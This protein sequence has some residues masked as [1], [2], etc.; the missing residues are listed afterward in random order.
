M[1]LSTTSLKKQISSNA[2]HFTQR[3][4]LIL[5]IGSLVGCSSDVYI[6]PSMAWET[7]H[8]LVSR[9]RDAIHYKD[10]TSPLIWTSFFPK[11]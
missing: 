2:T 7:R 9:V 10:V 1:M 5:V 3:L 8:I 11:K 6:G 4:F